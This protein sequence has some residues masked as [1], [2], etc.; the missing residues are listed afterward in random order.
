MFEFFKKDQPGQPLPDNVV[1][2]N[3][4]LRTDLPR[5][6]EIEAMLKNGTATINPKIDK[7]G[8]IIGEEVIGQ[9]GQLLAF[10]DLEEAEKVQKKETEEMETARKKDEHDRRLRKN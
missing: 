3:Q 9:K 8:K 1:S 10:I 7:N 5:A 6:K 4:S 2:F